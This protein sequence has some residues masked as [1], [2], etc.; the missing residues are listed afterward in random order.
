MILIKSSDFGVH[1]VESLVEPGLE[2]SLVRHEAVHFWFEIS[3]ECTL[4]LEFLKVLT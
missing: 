1:I 3:Q 4:R 2:V